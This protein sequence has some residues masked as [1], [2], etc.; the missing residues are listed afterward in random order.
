MRPILLHGHTRP[1]TQIKYNKDGD[2]LF[3]C[4][5]DKTPN[6]F[7]SHN[8]EH[9]GS[10]VG[11]KG[12]LFSIDPSADSRLLLTASSDN[13]CKVWDVQYGTEQRHLEFK[14]AV[15]SVEF[16]PVGGREFLVLTDQRMGNPGTLQ[17]FN[18]TDDTPIQSTEI[19]G[20]RA[21]VARWGALNKVVFLGHEDGSVSCWNPQTGEKLNSVKLHGG[22]VMDMQ[23]S[24]D[25]TYFI[26]ASKDQSAKLVDAHD[27]KVIKTYTSDRPLNSAS[28]SP[29]FDQVVVG[30]GQEARDVTTTSANQGRFE[31][32]FY[33]RVYSEEIGRVKG[34]FGPINTLA[35]HP[36]GKSYSSGGEEGYVR[37]H[38]FDDD[39]FSYDYEMDI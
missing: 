7:F 25:K 11:H 14:T 29:L 5:R 31:A 33:H 9:L 17:V 6:V 8:G 10:Y 24:Q 28:I 39:Y 19:T 20:A 32:C 30:G 37:I 36:N 35:F 1:L 21:T 23:L 3:T 34:H 12:A 4:A 18:M 26:S 16:S 13:S 22:P 27:L 2:L 15:R 38:H